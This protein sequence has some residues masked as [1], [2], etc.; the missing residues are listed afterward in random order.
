MVWGEVAAAAVQE[1]FFDATATGVSIAVVETTGV[2]A[3]TPRAAGIATA[4][5]ACMVSHLAT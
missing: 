3:G 2:V 4:V 5:A 1:V